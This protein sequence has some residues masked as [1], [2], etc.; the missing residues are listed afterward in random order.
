MKLSKATK[1]YEALEDKFFPCHGGV[2]M[3]VAENPN[4]STDSC[5]VDEQQLSSKGNNAF[6]FLSIKRSR[7]SSNGDLSFASTNIPYSVPSFKF[8]DDDEEPCHF[9]LN[10]HRRNRHVFA[11]CCS[12]SKKGKTEKREKSLR[13]RRRNRAWNA[14]DFENLIGV[15]VVGNGN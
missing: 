9:R 7:V 15:S 11:S 3:M 5:D 14:K 10:R 6:D 8:S 1:M 2:I 4:S 13:R 12:Q